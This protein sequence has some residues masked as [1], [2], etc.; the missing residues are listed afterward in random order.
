MWNKKSEKYFKIFSKAREVFFVFN[1][2]S[3]S[4]FFYALKMSKNQKLLLKYFNWA[5][6][7]CTMKILRL[8]VERRIATENRNRS[9]AAHNKHK[10]LFIYL[11]IGRRQVEGIRIIFWEDDSLTINALELKFMNY[12]KLLCIHRK[13]NKHILKCY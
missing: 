8:F 3:R 2:A 1:S 9:Q 10:F 7:A 11:F 12:K 13:I 5:T 4:S 6:K